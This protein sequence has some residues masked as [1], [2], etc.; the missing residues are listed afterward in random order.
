MARTTVLQSIK[1]LE[2]NG[3]CA[4]RK[5]QA[6]RHIGFLY[7]AALG[8]RFARKPVKRWKAQFAQSLPP[9]ETTHGAEQR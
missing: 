3:F 4:K 7:V 5:G 2:A 8:A 9:Q 6:D 1:K